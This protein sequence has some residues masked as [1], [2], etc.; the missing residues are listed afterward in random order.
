MT[1]TEPKKFYK[2]MSFHFYMFAAV[3]I[4]IF[5]A[6]Y[7]LGYFSSSSKME[8]KSP[9]QAVS[10][11]NNMQKTMDRLKELL[12]DNN[13]AQDAGKRMNFLKR[14]SRKLPK[15]LLWLLLLILLNLRGGLREL[16]K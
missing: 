9:N 3:L 1:E 10:Y 15:G 16:L 8:V 11:Q 14:K 6:L 4:L 2:R 5:L 12:L 7:C 13:E